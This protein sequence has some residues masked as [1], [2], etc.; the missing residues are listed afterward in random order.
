MPTILIV[1]DNINEYL[2]LM[3]ILEKEQYQVRYSDNGKNAIL[4]ANKFLIDLILLDI[5]LPEGDDYGY[6]VCKKIKE[7]TKNENIP[8]IFLTGKTGIKEKKRGFDVGGID[9]I[10]KPYHSLELLYRVK[11]HIELKYKTERIKELVEN[12]LLNIF[13]KKIAECLERGDKVEP[14][15]YSFVSILFA[16]FFEFSK[17][18]K[19]ISIWELISK[20]NSFFSEFD[21]IA[22]KYKISKIKTIGESYICAGGIPDMNYSNPIETV[23]AG[24]EIQQFMKQQ[25]DTN[26]KLRLGIHTGRVVA[27]VIGNYGYAYDIWGN[28]VNI[29]SRMGS[30]SEVG[31]VNISEETYK[32]IMDYFICIPRGEVKIRHGDKIRMYFV[33]K[34]KPEYSDDGIEPNKKFINII[35]NL[36]G[37]Q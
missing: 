37:N 32:I 5:A 1:E 29:A 10:T 22:K 12:L 26:W 6:E 16:D 35:E 23:L 30:R 3:K 20:L 21:D 8:I 25:T 14:Q 9:Y 28:D 36:Q 4:A 19:N 11:T 31:K 13:P 17:I 7:N 15:E 34:I 33:D 24:L 2:Y 27:G 18:I